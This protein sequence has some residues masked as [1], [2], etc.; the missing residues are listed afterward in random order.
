MSW[1]VSLANI[2]LMKGVE[3]NRLEVPLLPHQPLACNKS[4]NPTYSNSSGFM[5]TTRRAEYAETHQGI[6]V[7]ITGTH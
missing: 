7:T 3:G 4:L 2:S 5:D 1:G 6:S